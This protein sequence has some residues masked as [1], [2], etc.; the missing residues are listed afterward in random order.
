[1]RDLLGYNQKV[2]DAVAMAF[3][4]QVDEY[5]DSPFTSSISSSLRLSYLEHTSSRGFFTANRNTLGRYSG[6][7]NRYLSGGQGNAA[8]WF[9]L[10]TQP[11]N[12]PYM[13]YQASQRQLDSLTT[14]AQTAKKQELGWGN[15]FISWC[16]GE[17]SDELAPVHVSCRTDSGA[18]GFIDE[19]THLCV[20]NANSNVPGG[21]CTMKDGN[22][23]KIQT[24][25]AIIH[26]Y[27]EKAVVDSGMDQFIKADDL[28]A[29][30]GAILTAM[31][32]KVL[33]DVGGLL[34]AS[35][36]TSSD[37]GRTLVDDLNTYSDNNSSSEA[38]TA[39]DNGI[40]S[41]AVS[42]QQYQSAWGTIRST[43]SSAASALTKVVNSCGAAA[44]SARPPFGM[45][46]SDQ[47]TAAQNAL[48]RD[49]NPLIAQADAAIKSQTKPTLEDTTFAQQNAQSN[50]AAIDSPS[51]SLTVSGG[52]IIDRMALLNTNAARVK[53]DVCDN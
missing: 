45:R 47:V 22:P 29:A 26:K 28:D 30:F 8:A 2:G 40:L 24:P 44:L 12:N 4:D 46:Y 49:V 38:S 41:D 37:G 7:V 9:A 18:K 52:T 48:T 50:G 33:S 39:T 32:N 34:G 1:M 53:Q 15:G 14:G 43:A 23:G 42:A 3:F 13:L 19:T 6:D 16:A 5:S 35:V 11:Q 20:A 31:A 27:T 51:G 17:K 36:H 21:V 10:T 25:G